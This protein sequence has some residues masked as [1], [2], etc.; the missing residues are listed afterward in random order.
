MN[1]IVRAEQSDIETLAALFA[2]GFMHD[3]LYCHYIPYE[4]DRH[5]ILLQ[6]FRKYLTD[7]WEKLTVFVASDRSAGLCICPWDAE[8]TERIVL[9]FPAEKVY[10]QIN[11]SL[12]PQFYENYLILDLLAVRPD[13][14]G[15][16]LARALVEAFITIVKT[17]GQTGIVEIY[18]PGNLEFYQKLG[19]RLAHIQPVGE[20]LSAYL[21]EWK[22]E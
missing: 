19:F 9:P 16:G 7:Y 15:K 21:L 14:R 11:Q 20:T 10:E 1:L 3:P 4:N 17:T 18:E 6:I 2:E 22:E 13:M 12:A 8:G 5:G